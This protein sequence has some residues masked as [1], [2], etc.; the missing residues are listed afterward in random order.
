[1]TE[2][3]QVHECYPSQGPIKLAAALLGEASTDCLQQ[4]AKGTDLLRN[5]EPRFF[6]LGSKSC[7]RDSQ[8]LMKIG[9]EQVREMAGHL[10]QEFNR[11]WPEGMPS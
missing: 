5:P 11:S 7:G 4:T 3:L 2:E 1:M 6:I 9:I 8:F 10:C